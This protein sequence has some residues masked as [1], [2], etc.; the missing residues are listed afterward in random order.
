MNPKL[1][2]P[3]ISVWK[4]VLL[5]FVMSIFLSWQFINIRILFKW[6]Y[7]YFMAYCQVIFLDFKIYPML[8]PVFCSSYLCFYFHIRT[9]LTVCFHYV[10]LPPDANEKLWWTY[11]HL[12]V[13]QPLWEPLEILLSFFSTLQ[14]GCMVADTFCF[15]RLF[16]WL[17][18]LIR[19][20]LKSAHTSLFWILPSSS[21]RT[22]ICLAPSLPRTASNLY[23]CRLLFIALEGRAEYWVH[24]IVDVNSSY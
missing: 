6:Q 15:H 1:V 18:K 10:F 20:H 8:L 21:K 23:S 5:I 17:I 22:K 7:D 3:L 16:H 13:V 9:P 24:S 14:Q 11:D 19:F 4:E 2:R 12:C